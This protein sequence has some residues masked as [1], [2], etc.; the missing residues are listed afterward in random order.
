M[1]MNTQQCRDPMSTAALLAKELAQTS[2]ERDRRGG[3]AKEERD[4]I[5]E[6]GLLTLP[7]PTEYGGP[8]HTWPTILR[9]V[10]EIAKVDSSIAHLLG[11]HYL[12]LVT[13]HLM[14]SP[15]QKEKCY[16]GT[17]IHNWFWGNALNPRDRRVRASPEGGNRMLFNG[18]KRF[19]S[20]AKDSNMLLVSALKEESNGLIIAFIPSDREGVIIHDDWDNIGQRQTD[21]GSVSFHDVIIEEEEILRSPGPLGSPF[22][23]LRSSIAQL[24]LANIQLGIAEGAFEETKKSIT[25]FSG[26][27]SADVED[28]RRDPLIIQ[29]FGHLWIDIRSAVS[30][31]EEAGTAFQEAWEKEGN[32]DDGQRGRCTISISVAKVL[33]ARVGL[34][35]TNRMFELLGARATSTKYRYDRYWRNLR[36][37]SLHDPLDHKIQDIGDWALNARYPTPGFYS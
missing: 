12:Q 10:R 3:T 34:E 36:T 13:P 31:T 11:W 27:W 15:K 19:C 33:T 4:R 17:V 26:Q 16:A 18:V 37:L 14:G 1:G 21:S 2:V 7:V 25:A 22:A 8:G 20:G 35:V 5:R 6:S 28:K 23:S 30:L 32:L 9:V 29:R 24:L